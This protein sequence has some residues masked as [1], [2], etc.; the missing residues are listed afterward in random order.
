MAEWSF[1]DCNAYLGLPAN[2]Q[3]R[4][5]FDTAGFLAAMRAD[6]VE[7]AL[8]WHIGQHEHSPGV[9]N[10]AL[11]EE[12]AA[13]EK[14]HGC[15]AILPDGS[16]ELPAPDDLI[17]G[18]KAA[19]MA[20]VRAFP[21]AHGFFLDRRSCG[22]IIDA[23]IERRIPLLLSIRRGTD[24]GTVH[25]LLSEY[26]DLICVLCDHSEWALDRQ[27]PTLLENCPNIHID[28]TF[29]G[30]HGMIEWIAER[31]GAHRVLFG[32]GFPETAFGPMVHEIR[33]AEIP[34]ADRAAIAGGNLQRI[35]DEA[36]L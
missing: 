15:L 20:A 32:S 6:G 28:T 19:R 13:T 30:L 26:P 4:P 25:A 33:Q 9:G 5:I 16:R 29:F 31:F 22:K 36:D 10:A 7:Q 21:A 34:E 23:I 8:V 12:I 11:E 17:A 24:Y 35:L 2:R 3:V 27:I 14:L 18:M 1:F